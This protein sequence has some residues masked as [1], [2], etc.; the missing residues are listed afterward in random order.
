MAYI[1]HATLD[2]IHH[3]LTGTGTHTARY[4]RPDIY[5]LFACIQKILMYILVQLCKW[6]PERPFL[7]VPSSLPLSATSGLCVKES[8]LHHFRFISCAIFLYL[9][10]RVFAPC[11]HVLNGLSNG[12]CLPA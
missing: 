2:F 3:K 7:S 1:F 9:C 5:Q 4:A 11:S 8:F 10:S 6:L 12:P